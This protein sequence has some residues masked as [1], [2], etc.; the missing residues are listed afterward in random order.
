MKVRHG[1]DED[2]VFLDA[3]DQTVRKALQPA[4]ASP[5]V[6]GWPSLRNCPDAVDRLEDVRDEFSP[7]TRKLGVVVFDRSI[8]P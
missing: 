1:H 5:S 2:Q 4:P 7:Q 8:E 3:V 6:E